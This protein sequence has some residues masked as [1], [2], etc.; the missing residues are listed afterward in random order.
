MLVPRKLEELMVYV[1]RHPKVSN[2]GMTKLWKLVFFIDREAM[3]S[4]GS[5]ITG[6]EF[7]KYE[8]GPVPSR[9]EKHLRKL[10]REKAVTCE[11]RGHA[12][13][14][15]NEVS[16]LREPCREV[17]S[18]EEIEIADAVCSE[19]GGKTAKQ[20]SDISHQ[21]PAWHY[22]E[23]LQKLSPTLMAYGTQEDSDGL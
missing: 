1:S 12:G 10:C 7:I 14:K 15:L 11:Q 3:C 13:Y 23:M 9:G 18:D 5:S 17:F 20:L 22:A 19:F 4:L 21:Y 8:H 2:L 6:S 16:A